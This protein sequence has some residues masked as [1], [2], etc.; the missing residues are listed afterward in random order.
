MRR[1][2]SLG[3]VE[4]GSLEP[5][6]LQ[7]AAE[8]SVHDLNQGSAA[9]ATPKPVRCHTAML[10]ERSLALV[11][12]IEADQKLLQDAG[13]VPLD[14]AVVSRHRCCARPRRSVADI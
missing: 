2:E 5:A 13:A 10:D 4:E 3:A 12:V 11:A 8:R 6:D 9:A 1:D 7:Y 14:V